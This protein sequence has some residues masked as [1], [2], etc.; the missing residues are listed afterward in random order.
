MK[1]QKNVKGKYNVYGDDFTETM[2]SM[3]NKV[4]NKYIKTLKYLKF[5]ICA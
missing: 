1:V 4:K 2:P 3:E 5:A